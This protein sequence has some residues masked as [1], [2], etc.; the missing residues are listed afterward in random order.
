MAS[1]QL[2]DQLQAA[3]DQAIQRLVA[4]GLPV[5]KAPRPPAWAHQLLDQLTAP[6]VRRCSHL[7]ARPV[8]PWHAYAWEKLWRCS[9]CLVVHGSF[10]VPALGE[11]EEFTCD[12]CRRHRPH[13]LL[14]VII[15]MG[16]WVIYLGVCDDCGTVIP[17]GDA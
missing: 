14:P 7:V 1:V 9:D 15:R 8:Q 17:G 12:V 11:A 5:D 3:S 16:I 10:G 13:E 2:E 4:A 6:P